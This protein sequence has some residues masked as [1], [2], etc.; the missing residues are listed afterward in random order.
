ARWQTAAV[1][2]QSP[3]AA[4]NP[5]ADRRP[6]ITDRQPKPAPEAY[7]DAV[8]AA[9]DVYA[10]GKAEKIVLARAMDIT[11]GGPLDYRTVLEDLIA[12]NRHGYNFSLPLWLGERAEQSNG[13]M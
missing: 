13:Y 6:A 3:R 4:D 5:M 8:R 7:G 1:P 2:E 9:L 11:L 10:A 12:R